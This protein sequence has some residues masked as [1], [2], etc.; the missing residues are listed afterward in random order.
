MTASVLSAVT[1]TAVGHALAV[2]VARRPL[3]CAISVRALV[4]RC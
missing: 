2:L 4:R 3:G 1:A